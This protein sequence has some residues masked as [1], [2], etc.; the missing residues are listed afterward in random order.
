M[1]MI[2][3]WIRFFFGFSR[4]ETNGFLIL[5]PLLFL[6]LF[7]EPLYRFVGRSRNRPGDQSIS[8]SL[9]AV[10][11]EEKKLLSP[12]PRQVPAAAKLFP[13]DPNKASKKD[14][15]TLGVPSRVA[16]RITKFRL[17]GGTFRIKSDVMKIYGMDSAVYRRLH[18]YMTLPEKFFTDKPALSRTDKAVAV[19]FD[20]NTADTTQLKSIYG[21]GAR[22]AKRIIIYREKLGGFIS[23]TQLAEIYGLDSAVIGRIAVR[24][25]VAELY[26]PRKIDINAASDKELSAHP[27]ISPVLA[28]AI[29]A[30]R[31]QHG[32]FAA[33]GDIRDLRMLKKGEADK[34]IPYLIVNP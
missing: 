26:V 15:E 9:I 33:I 5:L 29:V 22:L 31:F 32:N 16:D 7:S 27:Y 11:E 6:I 13:F 4:T 12:R 18:G 25:Y 21:I 14:L 23:A 2:R 28:K 34:I 1:S 8:D 10:W 30:Y 19:K 3:K 17:K 24:T 20:L